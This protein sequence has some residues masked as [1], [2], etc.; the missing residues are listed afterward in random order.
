MQ[1]IAGTLS[2]AEEGTK[3]VL[4]H[5][6]DTFFDSHPHIHDSDRFRGLFNRVHK[7]QIDS[8]MNDATQ[9]LTPDNLSH[10]PLITNVANLPIAGPSTS[11]THGIFT[12]VQPNQP[13]F[14]FYYPQ[15]W[16]HYNNTKIS[17]L[18][19]AHFKFQVPLAAHTN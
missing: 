3:E 8:D 19:L 10:L 16:N 2:L 13:Q 4:I 7:Q 9:I 14:T 17:L 15:M 11:T 12:P 18:Y 5:K 6:I 1:E